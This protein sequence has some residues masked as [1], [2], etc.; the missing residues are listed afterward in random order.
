MAHH[1]AFQLSW[2][3]TLMTM[4]MWTTAQL[5]VFLTLLA[6]EAQREHRASLQDLYLL[7]LQDQLVIKI[8]IHRTLQPIAKTIMMHQEA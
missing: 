6:L 5:E 4:R 1:Q 8:Q 7:M 3:L 2:K